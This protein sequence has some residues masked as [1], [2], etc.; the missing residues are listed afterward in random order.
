MSALYRVG[1]MA[2]FVNTVK[3]KRVCIALLYFFPTLHTHTLTHT[4]TH[5]IFDLR[6]S[7]QYEIRRTPELS[8]HMLKYM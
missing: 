3:N 8:K 5:T 1:T 2:G 7:T 4:H 6:N